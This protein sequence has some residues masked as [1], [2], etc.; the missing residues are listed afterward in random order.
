MSEDDDEAARKAAWWRLDNAR[1][2]YH[3]LE[4][5]F[6]HGWRAGLAY[7]RARQSERM[8]ALE[9]FVETVRKQLA[10]ALHAVDA[11]KGTNDDDTES[12]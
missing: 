8:R 3:G 6:D 4:P 2:P 1:D 9:A 7:E 12:K 5:N 10:A 11:S